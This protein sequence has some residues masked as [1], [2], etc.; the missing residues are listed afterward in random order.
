MVKRILAMVLSLLMIFV[1]GCGAVSD[2]EIELG[3]SKYYDEDE[4]RDAAKAIRKH[5]RAMYNG[6]TL[7][8]IQYE[9]DEISEENLTYCSELE[10][11]KT[12][13]DCVVFTS[14]FE[15]SEKCDTTLEPDQTY[16][17]WHWYLAREKG[18]KWQL[19]MEGQG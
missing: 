13:V 9:G 8:R 7:L 2:A 10:P 1:I 19:V 18:G 3:D 15:T 12:F 4:L 14:V 6:C 5:F 16:E 11:D 17:E